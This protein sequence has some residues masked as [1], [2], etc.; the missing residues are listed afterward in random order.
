MFHQLDQ[1][2]MFYPMVWIETELYLPD[3]LIGPLHAFALLPRIVTAVAIVAIVLALLGLFWAVYSAREKVCCYYTHQ[4]SLLTTN[5]SEGIQGGSSLLHQ[6]NG[7]QY[8]V[9]NKEFY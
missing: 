1:A 3:Q 9:T 7:S 4:P 8:V 5:P 6:N 2:R